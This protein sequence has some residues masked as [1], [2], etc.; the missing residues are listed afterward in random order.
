MRKFIEM[1]G[2][3][4]IVE[5]LIANGVDTVFGLPGAQIYP[6]FDALQQRAI[7]SARSAPGTSRPAATWRSATRARRAGRACSRW[8]RGPASSTPRRRCAPRTGCNAP[9]LCVTGQVPHGL[10]RPR[11]RPSARAA[12]SARHAALADQMGGA[13]RAAGRRARDHQRGVPPDAV[14][15]AR[16]GRGR[17]GLGHDGVERPCRAAARRRHS[18]AAAALAAR[19]RGCRQ[20]ARQRPRGR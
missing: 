10:P 20:A 1:T 8:C 3:M 11:P 16:R 12:R 2:G 4:A 19:D 7:G 13:H 15:P 18:E 5:A 6:L 9:V 14:G 17:D